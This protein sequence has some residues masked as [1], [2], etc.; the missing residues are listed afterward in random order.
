MKFHRNINGWHVF[1]IVLAVFVASGIIYG[2]GGAGKKEDSK[3]EVGH[4]WVED[5]RERISEV[6]QDQG[7]KSE[8]LAIVDRVE[9]DLMELDRI[10]VTLYTDLGR[11]TDDY[12]STPDDFQEVIAKFQADREVVRDRIFDNDFKMRD[13]STP[14]EWRDLT[15]NR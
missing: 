2:C 5:M 8:M 3:F 4:E 9:K 1:L 11:L 15:S 12:D 7:R 14:D 13:L 6:I 10:V